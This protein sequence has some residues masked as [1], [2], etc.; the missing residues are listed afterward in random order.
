LTTIASVSSYSL[1]LCGLEILR[2]MKNNLITGVFLLICSIGVCQQRIVDSLIQR[3]QY[4]K[5]DTDKVKILID[6]AHRYSNINS[7]EGLK[8]GQKALNLAESLK[9]EY[10]TANAKEEIGRN[11]YALG[12]YHKVMSYFS[13]ALV[14]FEKHGYKR[15][16]VN[17]LRRMA[18]S[19]VDFGNGPKALEYDFKA[20]S[21]AQDIGNQ[22]E[23]AWTLESIG[24]IYNSQQNHPKALDYFLQAFKIATK[25]NNKEQ[26]TDISLDVGLA[27]KHLG[28]Y[29]KAMEYY[30]MCLKMSTELDNTRLVGLVLGNMGNVFLAQK[31]YHKALELHHKALKINKDGN[32]KYGVNQDISEFGLIYYT[33]AL[34][35]SIKIKPD[36]LIPKSR[37]ATLDSA[38]KYFEETCTIRKES[39]DLDNLGLSL[40]ELYQA[41]A[42]AG[43]YKD[44]FETFQKFRI[45]E[46]S[47]LTINSN[48]KISKIE[49]QNRIDLKNKQI[50]I[51][52]L[53][54][55]KKRNERGFFVGG[56][57]LLLLIIGFIFR[58]FRIQRKTN[59]ALDKSNKE[60]EL[61]LK[62][63]NHRVKN[64]LQIVSSLLEAQ[65][66]RLHDSGAIMALQE[67]QN[68]VEAISLIHQHLYQ[69]DNLTTIDIREY[70]NSLVENI[71][72]SYGYSKEQFKSVLNIEKLELDTDI[73][74]PLGLI[75]NELISNCFK[76]AFKAISNAKISINI[77]QNKEHSIDIEV[78]DNGPGI[79]A[80]TATDN[81]KSYGMRMIQLLI[82]QL[83]GNIT[84][85]TVNGCTYFI[86]VPLGKHTIMN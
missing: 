27:Y 54:V 62:E 37:K 43:N 66:S 38:I 21:I 61:L 45:L 72:S 6:I 56:I 76:H 44:A 67:A 5:E 19:L 13:E 18:N 29:P 3:L 80:N 57:A 48:E 10:G 58:S 26:I 34:D 63:L 74:I 50:A 24:I 49:A 23:M 81:P 71:S 8:Y 16:Q 46:D 32:Y 28:N 75:L 64:N 73:A 36:S 2:L 82:R 42:M 39:N 78:A 68:R 25:I 79:F 4:A 41:Y 84:S 12:D 86:T 22:V 83:K 15:E 53:E 52:Q 77:S 85:E 70:A 14:F 69:R 7:G 59:K 33:I 31:D 35:S 17:V 1:I 60:K 51:D 47:L 9:W 11:N 30:S 40:E 65:S 55:E 20:L